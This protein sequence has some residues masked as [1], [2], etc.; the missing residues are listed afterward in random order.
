MPD[1]SLPVLKTEHLLA[2]YYKVQVFGRDGDLRRELDWFPNLI[3]DN[4]LEL[5]ANQNSLITF[6]SVGTGNTAPAVTDTSL[7]TWVAGTQTSAGSSNGNSGSAPYYGYYRRTYRF[8]EGAAAGNLAEV[9]IGPLTNGT[10][11]FSRALL[12]DGG[13]SPTTITVAADEIL[14]VTYELRNYVPTGTTTPSVTDLTTG[15]NHSLTVRAAAAA[16]SSTWIPLIGTFTPG[17]T[18]A[19][20]YNGSIGATITDS[21]SGTADSS[22]SSVVSTYAALS[23]KRVVT[24]T[25]DLDDGNFTITALLLRP[26][27]SAGGSFQVGISPGVAK[28]SVKKFTVVWE[29]SWARYTP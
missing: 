10:N 2:G 3:T 14:E 11:L 16:G 29:F 25:W 21:P 28:T 19:V 9:G 8:A 7:Q 17:T 27:N 6:C 24:S 13:G 22:S 18:S 5:Y 15:V 23:H 12:L 4:G 20:A 26:T 1:G